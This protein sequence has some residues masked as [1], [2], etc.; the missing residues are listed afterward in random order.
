MSKK[1]EFLDAKITRLGKLLAAI[2]ALKDEVTTE[3]VARSLSETELLLR[4]YIH[5]LEGQ[6]DEHM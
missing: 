3:E 1:R 6:M 2:L 5:Q 4:G